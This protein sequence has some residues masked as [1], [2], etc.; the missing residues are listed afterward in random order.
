MPFARYQAGGFNGTKSRKM[1]WRR[2]AANSNA[3]QTGSGRLTLSG[4]ISAEVFPILPEQGSLPYSSNPL[5]PAVRKQRNPARRDILISMAY[6]IGVN[7]LTEHAK[8]I[9]VIFDE[10]V[11]NM[12]HMENKEEIKEA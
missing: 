3:D 6:Q 1:L 12:S 7:H 2:Y 4:N 8:Q 5:H 11:P 9:D 10:C